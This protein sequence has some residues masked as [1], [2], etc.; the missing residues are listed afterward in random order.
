MLFFLPI[1]TAEKPRR[2]P[3]ATC[4]VMTLTLAAYVVC[5]WGDMP[6]QQIIDRWGYIPNEG[7]PATFITSLFIHESLWRLVVNVWLLW[8]F[9]PLL[10][11]RLGHYPFLL[12]Y[13]A[14]G[15]ASWATAGAFEMGSDR[16]VAHIGASGSLAAVLGAFV[17][18]YPFADIKIWYFLGLIYYYGLKVG[19]FR[20][21]ALLVI[22]LWFGAQVSSLL[23]GAS[24]GP[25]SMGLLSQVGGFLFGAAAAVV[26]FG[27]EGILRETS[28]GED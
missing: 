13:L 25:E 5:V 9:G 18:L 14:G 20:V 6:H 3:L 1:G 10:E 15:M 19:T 16:L 8:L 2:Q 26:G 7:S 21:L 22:G 28:Y 27:K 24:G 12:L 23:V 17:V 11:S 4:A